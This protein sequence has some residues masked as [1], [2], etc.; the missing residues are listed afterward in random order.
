MPKPCPEEFRQDVVR[1]ARDRGAGVT[2]EQV[3][4][5]FGVHPTTLWKWMRRTDID[6]GAKPGTSSQE[7][8]ELPE[9]RKSFFSLLQKNVL[10][11][12]SWTTREERRIAIV[13]WIER[14]YHCRRRQAAL[15]RLPPIEGALRRAGEPD[16]AADRGGMRGS[17]S[18]SGRCRPWC[19]GRD[20][21][22]P[23]EDRRDPSTPPLPDEG[24]GRQV[25]RRRR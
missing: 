12:R 5:D 4:T 9:A 6:E 18:P 25:S 19:A 1:V 15:G 3:A 17:G 7:G 23:V 11:R 8:V 21:P 13:T 20:R 24:A 2:V 14:T 16:G 22:G 10:D